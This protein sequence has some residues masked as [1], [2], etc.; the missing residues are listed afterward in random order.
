M[1]ALEIMDS[2]MK[3]CED[4]FTRSFARDWVVNKVFNVADFSSGYNSSLNNPQQIN[5]ISITEG[6]KPEGI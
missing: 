5:E 2:L 4:V 6:E 1:V 3:K